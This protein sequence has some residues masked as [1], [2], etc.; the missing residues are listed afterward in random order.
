[1]IKSSKESHINFLNAPDVKTYYA[2]PEVK[3][4]SRSPAPDALKD[5]LRRHDPVNTPEKQK[6]RRLE[7]YQEAVKSL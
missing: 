3:E 5:F 1:M 2:S 7:S 6:K 4:S